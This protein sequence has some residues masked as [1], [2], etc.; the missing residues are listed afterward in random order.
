VTEQHA[1]KQHELHH[2]QHAVGGDVR[3]FH[4]QRVPAAAQVDGARRN[5]AHGERREHQTGKGSA[6][7]AWVEKY[8]TAVSRS[9]YG[10]SSGGT[11][12]YVSSATASK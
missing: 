1:V 5:G 6:V 7:D 9:A 3:R 10:G 12:Y 4:R 11:L 8:G 2:P